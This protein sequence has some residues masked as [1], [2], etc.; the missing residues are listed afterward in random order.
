MAVNAPAKVTVTTARAQAGQFWVKLSYQLPGGPD[1]VITRVASSQASSVHRLAA[2]R[3]R[4]SFLLNEPPIATTLSGQGCAQSKRRGLLSTE[5]CR[6]WSYT[7]PDQPPPPPVLDSVRADTVVIGGR[8]V[9]QKA[10]T[11]LGPNHAVVLPGQTATYCMVFTFGDGSQAVQT[12]QLPDC[13]GAIPEGTRTASVAGQA[14][15]D[16]LCIQWRAGGGTI[17]RSSCEA[18][19]IRFPSE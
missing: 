10:P 13:S 15:V 12:E 4:D 6:G 9:T 2:S 17:T 5:V 14:K 16:K 18:A 11:M 8:I 3:L 1:S 19:V 7:T